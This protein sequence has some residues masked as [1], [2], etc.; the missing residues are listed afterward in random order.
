VSLRRLASSPLVPVGAGVL[1][2]LA[3]PPWGWWPLAFLAFAVL[4][5]AL[6]EA[7]T[8]AQRYWVGWAFA[9]GWLFP[10]TLW[11]V[12]LTAPGYV[13]QV[14]IYATL[15]GAA[16][17][18]VP[19]GAWRWLALPGAITLFEAIRWRWPFGGVPLATLAMSQSAAPLAPVVRLLGPLLLTAAVV[20][21]GVALAA[22]Y[23]RRWKIAGLVVAGLVLL[24]LVSR[25][26]PNGEAIREIEIAVV[27]GGG[28]QGTQAIDTD[29]RIV[30]E[31]HVAATSGVT[32]SVDVVL[33]PEDVVNVPSLITEAR[34]WVELQDLARELDAWL[35]A[36]IFERTS[37]TSNAN[38][39]VAFG[40]DGS[41]ADRYDK[42]RLVPFG[43]FVPLRSLI[44]PLAP[45]YLPRRDTTPGDG[46]ATMTIEIDG[47]P[48]TVGVAISWEIFFEDRAREAIG[49][50]GQILLNPTNGSSYWLTILQ[51]Q[52]VASSRLRALETGRWVVQA[53][54]TGFSAVV[55][56][57]GHV[58]ERTDVG[59]ARVIQQMVELRS[60][61][62]LAT[63]V[64]AW[65][66]RLLALAALAGSRLAGRGPRRSA[67][68]G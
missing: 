25:V 22:A 10:A 47:E 66:M 58:V 60:G 36:G 31:R 18:L 9:A 51:T 48:V 7:S 46:P 55:D 61:N 34:E 29:A 67:K 1:L 65:P 5:Q 57:D 32:G 19:V 15:F 13:I 59:E 4:D 2:A 64:G 43:E 40:P 35:I 33:W 41:P 54:P 8:P 14:V 11:M 20:A 28:E 17:L 62:T 38:A 50:G 68:M 53:A 23:E 45:D 52:Q 49:E 30:F 21:G 3:M 63:V 42:V 44:E 16:T 27:Q 12:A 24:G 26:A 37:A 39:S 6:V 56:P